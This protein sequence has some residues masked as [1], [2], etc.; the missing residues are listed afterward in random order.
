MAEQP[1]DNSRSKQ[2][3]LPKQII[4]LNEEII[5]QV[6]VVVII[7]QK[8]SNSGGFMFSIDE[9]EQGFLASTCFLVAMISR[10]A[11]R[12]ILP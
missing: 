10:G 6:A 9:L 1:G 3:S 12:C 4:I 8:N 7:L 11:L 2:S 5:F